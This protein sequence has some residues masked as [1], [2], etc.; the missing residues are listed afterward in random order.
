MN[1]N[2]NTSI[3]S[4]VEY[5]EDTSSSVSTRPK[6]NFSIESKLQRSS[7]ST[8][9]IPKSTD[10]VIAEYSIARGISGISG[11][12][13]VQFPPAVPERQGPMFHAIQEWEGYVVEIEHNN[14]VAY[15]VDLTAGK[16]F[17]SEEAIIPFTEIS[18]HDLNIV[19]IGSIFRW[20]IGYEQTIEGT[21]KRVSNIVFRDLPR[22][23]ANDKQ[24]GI[25]WANKIAS[26]LSL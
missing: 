5:G 23:T 10:E 9:H 12:S 16:S 19:K 21:K 18:D 11:E 1:H 15:L 13:I 4:A 26:V 7:M 8:M 25:D 6:A 20:V 2:H 22:V 17:E 3:D 24:D 14:I